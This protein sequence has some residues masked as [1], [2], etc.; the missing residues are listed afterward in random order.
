MVGS[1]LPETDCAVREQ[2]KHD[3]ARNHRQD[4]DENHRIDVTFCV[5]SKSGHRKFIALRNREIIIKTC[6]S[7][8]LLGEVFLLRRKKRYDQTNFKNE[9]YTYESTSTCIFGTFR[10]CFSA[11]IVVGVYF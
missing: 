6:F 9:I 11:K 3:F 10:A 5:D 7:I 8:L 2:Q 1:V 4:F